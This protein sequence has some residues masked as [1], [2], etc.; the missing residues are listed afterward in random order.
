MSHNASQTANNAL[1]VS[2]TTGA[3]TLALINDYAVVIGL[4][5]SLISVVVGIFFH[6]Y[7]IKLKKEQISKDKEKLREEIIE[8][9][10]KENIAISESRNKGN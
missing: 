8:E 7:N 6:I 10:R 4:S 1:I 2:T 3:S 5:F 9:I